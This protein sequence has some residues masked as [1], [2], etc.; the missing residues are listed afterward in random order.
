MGVTRGNVLC[1]SLST[2]SASGELVQ[3]QLPQVYG[4]Q[5][6]EAAVSSSNNL[7]LFCWVLDKSNSPFSVVRHDMTVDDLKKEIKKE[8][9]PALDDIVAPS[10]PLESE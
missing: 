8:M 1:T 10:L 4:N 2:H 7:K 5:G 9:E 3:S 6:I